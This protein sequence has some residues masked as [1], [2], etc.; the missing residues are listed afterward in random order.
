MKQSF[1][2]L[3]AILEL[4]KQFLDVVQALLELL[5]RF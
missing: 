2:F 3:Y 5:T 4:M 1:L